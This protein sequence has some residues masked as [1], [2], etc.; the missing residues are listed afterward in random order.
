MKEWRC[1]YLYAALCVLCTQ[2]MHGVSGQAIRRVSTAEDLKAAITGG[3][4]DIEVIAHLDLTQLA[5][6]MAAV[7][8]G[9]RFRSF[10]VRFWVPSFAFWGCMS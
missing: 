3:A 2:H 9:P 6:G 5:P 10:R 8:D 1:I 7:F 4:R